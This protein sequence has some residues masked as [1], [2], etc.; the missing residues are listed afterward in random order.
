MGDRVYY[1]AMEDWV[2]QVGLVV[3]KIGACVDNT[4]AQKYHNSYRA[5]QTK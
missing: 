2:M 5:P 1:W 3:A 4:M